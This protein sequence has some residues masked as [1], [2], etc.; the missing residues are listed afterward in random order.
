MAA[1]DVIELKKANKMYGAFKDTLR[2]YNNAVSIHQLTCAVSKM[3]ESDNIEAI[4]EF[5][6]TTNMS[7]ISELTQGGTVDTSTLLTES[8]A[9][10]PSVSEI[11]TTPTNLVTIAATTTVSRPKGGRPKGSRVKARNEKTNKMKAILVE[12]ATMIIT[13]KGESNERLGRHAKK[14]ILRLLEVKHGLEENSL[15]AYLDT[16]KSRVRTKNPSGLGKSQTLP[17]LDL[18]PLLVDYV[19]RLSEIGMPLNREGVIKLAISMITGQPM[20]EKVIA[21]K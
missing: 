8:S 3:E 10:T 18:E 19:V 1:H 9:N 16:I 5:T 6:I 13:C 2:W 14:E 20:E 11:T 7:P 4:M 21:W 17:M 15:D 12:A